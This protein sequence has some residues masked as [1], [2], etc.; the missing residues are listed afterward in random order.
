MTRHS[1]IDGRDLLN[2]IHV[3]GVQCMTINTCVP[4]SNVTGKQCTTGDVQVTGGLDNGQ[5]GNLDYCYNGNWS[6]FCTLDRNTATVACRQL[7]FSEFS[8]QFK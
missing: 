4:P 1:V 2:N 3:A 8:C 7:H 5:E 6:P